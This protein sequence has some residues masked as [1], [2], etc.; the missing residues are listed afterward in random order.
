MSLKSVSLT[1]KRLQQASAVIIA[2]GHISYDYAWT[3]KN[4]KLVVDS[5]NAIKKPRKNVVKA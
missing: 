3:S 2:T 5:R 1:A 4:A